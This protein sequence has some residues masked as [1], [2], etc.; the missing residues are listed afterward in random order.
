MKSIEIKEAP[1]FKGRFKILTLRPKPENIPVPTWCKMLKDSPALM[2]RYLIK[3]SPVHENLIMLGAQ[4]G[5]NLFIR[6]LAGLATV[7]LLITRAG[8]G[9]GDTAPVSGNT[10][11]ETPIVTNILRAIGEVPANDIF[12]SEWY[13]SD[14][15]LPNNT[16]REFGLFCDTQIFSRALI[17]P[18]F[19]KESG[20]DTLVVYEITASNV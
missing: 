2:N 19:E 15:D 1:R 20:Q 14:N 13:A 9:T 6:R 5:L 12:Y 7:P 11:L 17:S 3:S 10:N 18:V 4:T 8:F 16:Y